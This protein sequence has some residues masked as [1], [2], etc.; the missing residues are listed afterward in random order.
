[1]VGDLNAKHTDWNSRLITAKGLRLRDYADKNSCL[2]NGPDSPTTAL[3]THN[4]TPSVLDIFIVKDFDV[5]VH[6]TVCAALS[7][8]HLPILIGT[9]CRSSFQN[10]PA[11][12]EFMRMDWVAFQTYL[13]DTI[14][15]NSTVVDDRQST[16]A[17]R[18]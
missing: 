3:Y 1:M 7:T 13:K 17:S 5:P 11:R 4:A 15:E 18:S 9:L 14:P 16:S 10:I 6:L 8:D 2:I 12:P